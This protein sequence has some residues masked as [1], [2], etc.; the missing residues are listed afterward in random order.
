MFREVV[1][2]FRWAEAM[3]ILDNRWFNEIFEA[4]QKAWTAHR[5]RASATKQT[6]S[7]KSPPLRVA[8][9]AAKKDINIDVRS[10][11]VI[12]NKGDNDILS[13]PSAHLFGIIR[14]PCVVLE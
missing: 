7:R 2:L 4:S 11:N 14:H 13:C 1:E 12:E 10:R 9:R 6:G 8:K 5:Q 3:V